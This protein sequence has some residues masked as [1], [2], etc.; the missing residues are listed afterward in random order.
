MARGGIRI[1]AGRPRKGET[2]EEKR[3]RLGLPAPGVAAAA[4]AAAAAIPSGTVLPQG[5]DL[6]E[7]LS[8][9]DFLKAVQRDKRQPLEVRIRAAVAAAPYTHAKLRDAGMGLKDERKKKARDTGAA[10]TRF[11][12]GAPPLALVGAGGNGGNGGNTK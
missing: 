10:S 12:P 6:D 2:A 9:L 1:G 4:A 3:K 8:P 5:V 11:A 7:D